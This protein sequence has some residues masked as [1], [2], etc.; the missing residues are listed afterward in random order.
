MS[1]LPVLR[2]PGMYFGKA[3]VLACDGLCS[4][5]WGIQGRPRISFSDNVDDYVYQKD[6]VAG[7]APSRS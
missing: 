1:K 3:S 7:P 6:S 4:M 5:A 2:R